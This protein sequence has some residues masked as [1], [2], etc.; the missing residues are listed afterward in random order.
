[1]RLLLVVLL[2][3]SAQA[4]KTRPDFSG[5]WALDPRPHPTIKGDRAAMLGDKFAAKQD[6]NTLSLEITAL[7]R[8]F[9]AVYNLD[10][11]DSRLVSPMGPGLPDEVIISRAIWDEQRLVIRTTATEIRD[12]KPVEIQSQ[13][14]IWID[15]NGLLI[16]ERSGTPPDLVPR[17]VSIYRRAR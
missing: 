11:S 12:G 14:V 2:L 6:A 3:S 9:Q 15:A 16:L 4:T 1:M 10:G 7:G 5:E 17:T 8:Q 13:R